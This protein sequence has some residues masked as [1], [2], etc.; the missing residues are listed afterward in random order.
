MVTNE[1]VVE[2]HLSVVV[3]LVG[4]QSYTG[5]V[6]GVDEVADL[7]L[8][9]IQA[10]V[11]FD[12]VELADSDLILVGDDVIAMGFPLG[13]MLQGSSPTITKGIISAKRVSGSGVELL[14]TD[15][16]V[17][18]GNSGGPLFGSDGRVV[19]INT[20]KLFETEDGRPAE[21]IGLAVS[22]NEVKDRLDS[23][24]K[25]QNIVSGTPTPMPTPT[26]SSQ[27][28]AGWFYVDSVELPHED[29]GLIESLTA[30]DNV[31]NFRI[32]SEFEVP[33]DAS[34][35]R[36]DVG[37]LFRNSGG[38]NLSYVA[39]TYDGR[40]SHRVRIDGEST[41]IENGDVGS[42]NQ[43]AG[44][45]NTMGL[46]VVENR[47]WLFVNS[48]YVTDLDVS[49]GS[50][51]GELEVATGL[52]EG[53]EVPGY[54]T[55]LSNIRAA[56]L[57]ILYGPQAGSLTKDSSFISSHRAGVDI[58]FAYAGVEFRTPDDPDKW[59][60]GFM[61][62]DRGGEDDFL[63]F[64]V[65]SSGSWRVDHATYSGEDWQTL[66]EGYSDSIDI[67][68]P[69][70]NRLEVLFVGQV[71]IVYV[72]GRELGTADISSITTSG[73]V[74]VAYGIYQ[75]DDHSTARFEDFTVWGANA[76]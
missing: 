42:W 48:V 51:E 31:R 8:V 49:A 4:G 27:R 76:P 5:R 7:A 40:Y 71:A 53:D 15:A 56:E 23:L 24:S 74:G 65:S 25:G 12:P 63:V 10:R 58:S 39:V 64:H 17:N 32:F 2:D 47:G 11:S 50:T 28:G 61:F 60:A 54:S 75:G 1:H 9:D 30:L 34:V 3:R 20:S 35:G 66:K 14:Q 38:G 68:H 37:F 21:G 13:D 16:A 18:P 55:K 6:L 19:G 43:N 22:I 69:T 26:P 59:S 45:T 44:D 33:Y 57:S 73:D 52:F 29:D 36:W 62:R 46:F 70:L 67:K 72:N 41:T